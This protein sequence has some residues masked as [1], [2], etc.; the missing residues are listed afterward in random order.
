MVKA[1][2]L[3]RLGRLLPC[4]EATEGSQGHPVHISVHGLQIVLQQR[5]EEAVV[6]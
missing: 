3:R 2:R 1:L 5:L 6:R 4:I